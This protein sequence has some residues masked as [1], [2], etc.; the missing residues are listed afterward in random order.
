MNDTQTLRAFADQI[1][2]YAPPC[3]RWTIGHFGEESDASYLEMV[4]VRS[5]ISNHR[6]ACDGSCH[7]KGS[8]T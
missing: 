3:W 4:A 2:R 5:A 7:E 8:T 6:P 1:L